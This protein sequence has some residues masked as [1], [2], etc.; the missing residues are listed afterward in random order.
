MPVNLEAMIL[1]LQSEVSVLRNEGAAMRSELTA[2]KNEIDA[3]NAAE[4][5]DRPKK[6]KASADMVYHVGHLTEM[7]EDTRRALS[8][9]A[10]NLI[11]SREALEHKIES[12]NKAN[13]PT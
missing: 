2:L 4:E 5:T 1:E 12:L 13:L 3:K 7:L 9:H 8:E 6:E 10:K 11:S